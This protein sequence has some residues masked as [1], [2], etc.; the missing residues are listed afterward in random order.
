L[1]IQSENFTVLS[2]KIMSTA[3]CSVWPLRG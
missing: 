2:S 1:K 3:D